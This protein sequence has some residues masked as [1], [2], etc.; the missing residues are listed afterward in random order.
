MTQQEYEALR[1]IIII[2]NLDYIFVN[3]NKY[4]EILLYFQDH[5]HG[6]DQDIYNINAKRTL[7]GCKLEQYLNVSDTFSKQVELEKEGKSFIIW[8]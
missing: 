1:R 5:Y 8:G 7:F 6:F 3:N 2:N 4:F